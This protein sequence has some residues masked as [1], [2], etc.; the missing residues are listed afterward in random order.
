MQQDNI[1]PFYPGQKVVAI[2]TSGRHY[3]TGMQF[4]KDETYTVI[5]CVQCTCGKWMIVCKE[6]P[7]PDNAGNVWC[8][9][10]CD[11]PYCSGDA[12]YFRPVVED[13]QSITLTEVIKIESPLISVN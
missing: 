1:P 3:P 7:V 9:T 10:Q 4:I 12:K 8:H 13:F 2:K 5:K 11:L 6:L